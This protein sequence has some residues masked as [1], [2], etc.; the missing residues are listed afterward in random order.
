[1]KLFE[2]KV[3][4]N[5]QCRVIAMTTHMLYNIN[6]NYT[7]ILKSDWVSTVLISALIGLQCNRTVCIIPK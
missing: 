5:L 7:K 6:H 3:M 1:M 4:L 2:T